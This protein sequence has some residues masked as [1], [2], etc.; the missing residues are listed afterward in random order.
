MTFFQ[1]LPAISFSSLF[2]SLS[3]FSFWCPFYALLSCLFINS[4]ASSWHS[5]T[6]QTFGLVCFFS[7][8]VSLSLVRFLY[9]A[10]SIFSLV[11]F[12]YTSSRFCICR[13]FWYRNLGRFHICVFPSTVICHSLLYSFRFSLPVS[14]LKINFQFHIRYFFS[15]WSF[16]SHWAL[17][18][19]SL[20]TFFQYFLDPFCI[21]QLFLFVLSF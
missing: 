20:L 5:I 14:F 8:N 1:H 17:G 7:F 3:F 9:V 16:M 15:C 10:V 21:F 2:V 6:Y 12:L 4:L 18:L 11:L 19:F 13:L